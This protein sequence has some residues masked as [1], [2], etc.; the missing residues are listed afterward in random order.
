MK[1][2]N[3]LDA[4]NKFGDAAIIGEG[5]TPRDEKVEKK[6]ETLITIVLQT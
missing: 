1:Y 3:K 5:G 4:E 6:L 2:I